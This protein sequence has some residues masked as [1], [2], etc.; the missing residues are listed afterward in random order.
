LQNRLQQLLPLAVATAGYHHQPQHRLTAVMFLHLLPL[1]LLLLLPRQLS[2]L[3]HQVLIF[4]NACSPQDRHRSRQHQT[5]LQ[6]ASRQANKAPV[7]VS[8][9][10]RLGMH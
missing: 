7:K 6:Q 5:R 8:A 3:L 9:E 1:L 2:L 4:L 10:Q